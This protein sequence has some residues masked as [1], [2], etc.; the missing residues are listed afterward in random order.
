M[1]VAIDT[2]ITESAIEHG[3]KSRVAE[4]ERLGH[5]KFEHL[6]TLV[7]FTFSTDV[8]HYILNEKYDM[9]PPI[10]LTHYP[11]PWDSMTV[12]KEAFFNY[13]KENLPRRIPNI[14]KYIEHV[15]IDL[16]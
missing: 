8:L 10:H 12:G 3:H 1:R 16:G 15:D 4:G 11:R 9:N 6:K 5:F 7:R 13:L 14:G 2:H